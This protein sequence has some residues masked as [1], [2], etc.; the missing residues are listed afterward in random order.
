VLA[1][2]LVSRPVVSGVQLSP[3]EPLG[4]GNLRNVGGFPGARGVDDP[5]GGE[6]DPVRL[7]S[8]AAVPF[9]DRLDRYRAV[10]GQS[11]LNSYAAKYTGT[12]SLARIS[13]ACAST[14]S[15]WSASARASGAARHR[16]APTI[17]PA[18]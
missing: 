12:A 18:P 10:E 4:A 6:S 1:G 7:D 13:A 2:E 15:D 11:N 5:T 17:G 8:E 3:L 16:P 9:A 14:A